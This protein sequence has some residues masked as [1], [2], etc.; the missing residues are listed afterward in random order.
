MASGDVQ[1]GVSDSASQKG[2]VIATRWYQAKLICCVR[3]P[4][5]TKVVLLSPRTRH[6]ADLR[7]TRYRNQ[8]TP[9]GSLRY[10][11]SRSKAAALRGGAPGMSKMVV[12]PRPPST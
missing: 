11:L 6:T 7:A 4:R 1:T 5:R 3:I 10:D 9:P 8:L 2:H 12:T